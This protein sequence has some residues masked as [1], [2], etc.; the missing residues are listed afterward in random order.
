MMKR[1]SAQVNLC[2]LAHQHPLIDPDHRVIVV[3]RMTTVSMNIRILIGSLLL[4]IQIC[5]N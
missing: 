4:K 3:M 1:R 5:L 2:A